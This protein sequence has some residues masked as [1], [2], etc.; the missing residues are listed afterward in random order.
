MI[1]DNRLYNL[2][3]YLKY[4]PG[5]KRIIQQFNGKDCTEFFNTTHSKPA[6]ITK[7]VLPKY[8]VIDISNLQRMSKVEINHHRIQTEFEQMIK[9]ADYPCICAR[10]AVYSNQHKFVV[11]DSNNYDG[12][13]L[14]LIQFMIEQQT[15]WKKSQNTRIFTTF[16]V[17]F[18]NIKH[19]DI[20]EF[21]TFL[22]NI[23]EYLHNFEA[24]YKFTE[25]MN[26]NH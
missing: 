13:C 11:T 10:T 6:A 5:G 7:L 23:L 20:Y 4:H 9:D 16:I 26:P 21:E 22:F 25:S 18:P 19:V 17:C 12:L 3:S 2:D 8:Y 14:Q 15:Q 24:R 1:I